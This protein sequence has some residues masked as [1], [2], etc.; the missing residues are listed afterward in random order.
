MRMLCPLPDRSAF[1]TSHPVLVLVTVTVNPVPVTVRV[2]LLVVLEA[3]HS[4]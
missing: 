1:D 4:N 2:Y 3:V